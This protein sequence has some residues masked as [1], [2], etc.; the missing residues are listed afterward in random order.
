MATLFRPD[1]EIGFPRPPC[2]PSRPRT[3][4]VHFDPQRP[5]SPPS[6]DS[7]V[8]EAK[9]N[10]PRRDRG[11]YSQRS[12]SNCPVPKL[13]CSPNLIPAACKSKGGSTNRTSN[14]QTS[15]SIDEPLR[16]PGS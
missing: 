8:V 13:R 6:S 5:T 15:R 1:P 2:P 11:S 14:C 9:N 10:Y 3:G 16:K 12:S 4:T 7:D